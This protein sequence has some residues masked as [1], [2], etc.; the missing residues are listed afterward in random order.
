MNSKLMCSK[1]WWEK[2]DLCLSFAV[3][4]NSLCCCFVSTAVLKGGKLFFNILIEGIY[5]PGLPVTPQ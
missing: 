3:G 5:E 2:E 4:I 1:F